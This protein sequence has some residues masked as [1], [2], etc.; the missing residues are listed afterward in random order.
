MGDCVSFICNQ[1]I[2]FGLL[3]RF[4][5]WKSCVQNVKS[6]L[7]FG[8]GSL[9]KIQTDSARAALYGPAVF[10]LETW[11]KQGRRS[12]GTV[13]YVLLEWTSAHISHSGFE[14]VLFP[15]AKYLWL[16]KVLN[17]RNVNMFNMLNNNEVKNAYFT[18]TW[19]C[20]LVNALAN[21]K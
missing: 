1:L 6:V 19:G 7:F 5:S 16:R 2:V 13:Q 4:R 18:L 20:T 10:T 15:L 8:N 9:L 12:C 21:M 11:T 3:A 14:C 17:K